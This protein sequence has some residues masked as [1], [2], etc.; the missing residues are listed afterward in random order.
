MT[1]SH[2]QSTLRRMAIGLVAFAVLAVGL[3]I[4]FPGSSPPAAGL[5]V[6]AVVFSLA[7]SLLGQ[8]LRVIPWREGRRFGVAL[9]YVV[10]VVAIATASYVAW[11]LHAWP[12]LDGVA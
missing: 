10:F 9:S 12:P 11:A 4:A 3:R 1:I 7:F 5:L 2:T 6:L 8:P